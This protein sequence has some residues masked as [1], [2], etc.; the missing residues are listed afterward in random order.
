MI[1]GFVAFFVAFGIG[2]NDVANAFATSVG[3]G[4]L[5]IGQAL[6]IA[7]VFEFLGAFFLGKGVADTVRSK[8]A[9]PE[10]FYSMP[11]VFMYGNLSALFA[12]GCW[13][14]LASYLELPVS[15]THSIVGGIVGF[16]ITVDPDAIIWSESSDEF[17]YF[18][19]ISAIV[20]SWFISPILSAI[21]AMILFFVVRL[22]IL[23]SK[24]SY[25]RAFIFFP[26]LV[27][28]TVF[29]NCL[30]ILTKGAEAFAEVE[31]MVF[32]KKVVISI[33]CGVAVAIVTAIISHILK[34]KLDAYFE[35]RAEKPGFKDGKK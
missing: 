30:F 4:A 22:V 6:L 33:G 17:P 20:A 35:G 15:T 3:S 23:R 13:L 26:V 10:F 19:G 7:A 14:L 2:A 1:G 11:E 29:I 8:I 9:D 25:T 18:K 28:L 5:S 27:F 16:A 21:L 12:A 31:D 24:D 32:W 34:K